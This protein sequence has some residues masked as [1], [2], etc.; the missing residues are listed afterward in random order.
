M[1]RHGIL[2]PRRPDPPRQVEDF[3]ED[4]AP[5]S[6]LRLKPEQLD[7]RQRHLL[8]AYAEAQGVDSESTGALRPQ[9]PPPGPS[10]V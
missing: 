5:G 6:K 7:A 2:L 9:P 4:A 3:I 8:H 1:P 10:R